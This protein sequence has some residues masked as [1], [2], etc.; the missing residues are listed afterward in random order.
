M[1]ITR[2]GAGSTAG[3]VTSDAHKTMLLIKNECS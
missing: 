2:Y 1:S 3:T